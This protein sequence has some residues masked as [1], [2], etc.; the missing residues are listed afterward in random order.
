MLNNGRSDE[1]GAHPGYAAGCNDQEGVK[2]HL[3]L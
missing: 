2:G 3:G 1:Y